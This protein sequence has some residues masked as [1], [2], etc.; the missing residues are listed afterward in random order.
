MLSTAGAVE[1]LGG[2]T[3]SR[4]A[5]EG[6]DLQAAD[7]SSIRVTWVPAQHAPDWV[8][9]YTGEVTGF[10]ISGLDLPTVYV[11]GDNSSM[12]LVREIAQRCGPIDVALLFAG[13]G[14]VAPL[15]AALTFTGDEAAEA[16][17]IL[18]SPH[19]VV[20]HANG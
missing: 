2:A 6:I 18:G 14:V 19:V 17:E 5:W 3:T 7:G 11:S 8:T 1:R 13:A 9:P 16:A 12:E 4:P 15:E 10:V 20:I